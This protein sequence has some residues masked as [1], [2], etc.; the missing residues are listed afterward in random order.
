MAR[1]GPRSI[2]KYS[3][4]CSH[5]NHTPNER[6]IRS[7]SSPRATTASANNTPSADP[8]RRERARYLE[9]LVAHLPRNATVLELVCCGRVHYTG[10]RRGVLPHRLEEA[11]PP[12]VP[13]T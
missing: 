2:R 6:P 3:A 9:R 10:A 8:C 4:L 1:P 7:V 5:R 13:R 11:H 12:T